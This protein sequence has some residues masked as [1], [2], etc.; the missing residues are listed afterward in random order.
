[1]D[2]QDGLRR[3]AEL[4]EYCMAATECMYT[5]SK[6]VP[7]RRKFAEVTNSNPPS[8]RRLLEAWKRYPHHDPVTFETLR[9]FAE[10]RHPADADHLDAGHPVLWVPLTELPDHVTKEPQEKVP[11]SACDLRA[12]IEGFAQPR[13][14]PSQG[15]APAVNWVENERRKRNHSY[16]Q[17]AAEAGIDWEGGVQDLRRFLA[18][19]GYAAPSMAIALVIHLGRYLAVDDTPQARMDASERLSKMIRDWHYS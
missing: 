8:V 19:G 3:A 15:L 11:M 7:S 18:L 14:S 13:T 2:T 6:K 1:M 16:E 9:N 5:K 4:I 12:I 17:V 10:S